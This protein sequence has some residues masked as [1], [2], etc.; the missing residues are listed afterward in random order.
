MSMDKVSIICYM[1]DDPRVLLRD[2]DRDSYIICADMGLDYALR[3]GIRPDLV[4]G[5][6]DSY[7][8]EIPADIPVIRL[9]VMKDDTDTGYAVNYALEHGAGEITIY[10]G[11][12]GRF[13][14]S[15]AN[16]QI[17]AGAAEK[18]GTAR[19]ITRDDIVTVTTGS[20]E[21]K[22]R[23]G[24]YLSVFPLGGAARGVTIR[25]ALYELNDALLP[26]A[27]SLGASNEITD[28]ICTVSTRSGTLALIQS[29]KRRP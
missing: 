26:C 11:L 2:A 10:G 19:L 5:D 29:R 21:I 8:G 25:G 9:P 18:I 27:G 4:I 24:F 22:K 14:Q 23:E 1:E 12:G 13:D 28:E 3:A 17:M 16:L 20:A 15:A 6:L 7:R